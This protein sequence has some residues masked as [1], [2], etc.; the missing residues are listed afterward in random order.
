MRYFQVHQT[1]RKTQH[2][3]KFQ[4]QGRIPPKL[5][6]LIPPSNIF[7]IKTK[8][9]KV[10]TGIK[11]SNIGFNKLIFQP[12]FNFYLHQDYT[13]VHSRGLFH[14]GENWVGRITCCKYLRFF[15]KCFLCVSFP[16]EE[17]VL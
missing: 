13:G 9:P 12:S 16:T 15:I 11:N 8:L 2:L 3:N 6:R 14:F 17:V 10:L 5:C 4:I 1:T 7:H